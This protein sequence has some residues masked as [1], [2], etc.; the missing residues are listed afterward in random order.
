[1][2]A[3]LHDC[4]TWAAARGLVMSGLSIERSAAG[5]APD[6][7]R[8]LLLLRAACGLGA[9][10]GAALL[11]EHMVGLAAAADD[12]GALPRCAPAAP[13]LVAPHMP[14]WSALRSSS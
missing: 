5:G 1:M 3:A 10:G 7:C 9:G 13:P 2:I 4:Y 11:Q 6:G 14:P 8:S 12:A